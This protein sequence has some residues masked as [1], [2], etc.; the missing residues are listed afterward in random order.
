[1]GW[2]WWGWGWWGWGRAPLTN[3][4]VSRRNEKWRAAAVGTSVPRRTAISCWPQ[5]ALWP[6]TPPHPPPSS[7]PDKG[8]MVDGGGVCCALVYVECSSVELNMDDGAD[9]TSGTDAF[10]DA[11]SETW[12]RVFLFFFFSQWDQLGWHTTAAAPWGLC[13][14]QTDRWRN[15]VTLKRTKSK[16]L[17]QKRS[18]K[19]FDGGFLRSLNAS[20]SSQLTPECQRSQ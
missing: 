2:C 9:D 15:D 6:L 14:T 8:W 1:M 18:H 4:G 13:Q 5:F 10:T 16:P 3:M 11:S 12:T 7:R 20:R 19:P 17:V